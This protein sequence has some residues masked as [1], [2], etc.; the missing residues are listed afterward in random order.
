MEMRSRAKHG[1]VGILL[2]RRDAYVTVVDVDLHVFVR[3]RTG[4]LEVE[5]HLA[6]VD[7]GRALVRLD[8]GL[9]DRLHPHGLPDAG[10]AGVEASFGLEAL[11]AARVDEVF[12]R[13]P[14]A[15]GQR[16]VAAF[17]VI[18]DVQRKGILPAF[19]GNVGDFRMS[20]EHHRPEIYASKME[21]DALPALRVAVY[22]A[23]VPEKLVGVQKP[24]DAGKSALDRKRD[25]NLAVPFLGI[26]GVF[27]TLVTA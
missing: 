20:D 5:A 1:L 24:A 17:D 12:G 22:R 18:R 3:L 4:D 10:N 26:P 8:V 2:R 6:V 16:V 9:G 19:M 7:V 15:H 27:V 11:L 14:Y 25:Q 13:I 21:Q 23:C